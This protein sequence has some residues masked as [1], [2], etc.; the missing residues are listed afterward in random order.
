MEKIGQVNRYICKD[1][2][3]QVYTVNLNSGTTPF[4]VKCPHCKSLECFSAFYQI[5][6]IGSN[7]PQSEITITHCFYRPH[8]ARLDELN[9]EMHAIFIEKGLPSPPE[10]GWDDHVLFGGLVFDP[11][12]KYPAVPEPEPPFQ[13][14]DDYDRCRAFMLKTYGRAKQDCDPFSETVWNPT[15]AEDGKYGVITASK[16]EFRPG[17]PLFLFRASD[18]HMITAVTVYADDCEDDGCPRAHVEGVRVALEKIRGWRAAN[19]DLVKK[20]D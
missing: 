6:P 1:C 4:G 20:P 16:K 11:L 12:G 17:E 9:A 19:K 8:L 10:R 7:R 18:K 13:G 5:G 2:R 14:E 15:P 3:K